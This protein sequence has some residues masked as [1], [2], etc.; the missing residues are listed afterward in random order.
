M[1]GIVILVAAVALVLIVNREREPE[2]GGRKL[3]EW[4]R[5]YR[6]P[7]SMTSWRPDEQAAQAVH[8]LGTDAVPYLL[9]WMSYEAPG[10]R[11]DLEEMLEGFN[12][13]W[14][15]PLRKASENRPQGKQRD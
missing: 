4:V 15:C 8:R 5:R 6:V 13:A 11:C 10:W 1:L 9:G 2:Y 3:S 7:G 14:M 12:L